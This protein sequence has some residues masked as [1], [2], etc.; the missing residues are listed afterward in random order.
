MKEV[1]EVVKEVRAEQP[2]GW[3]KF[4]GRAFNLGVPQQRIVFFVEVQLS[5]VKD[6]LCTPEVLPDNS[7]SESQ[8]FPKRFQLLKRGT[9]LIFLI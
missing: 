6:P 9:F 4:D 7:E 5:L 1:G 2:L 3:C 8:T